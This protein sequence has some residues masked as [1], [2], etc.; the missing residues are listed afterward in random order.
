MS[1]ENILKKQFKFSDIDFQETSERYYSNT[2]VAPDLILSVV[3]GKGNYSIPTEK[4]SN[5]QEYDAY[6]FG[7]WDKDNIYDWLTADLLGGQKG[8]NDVIG[9]ATK[10]EIEEL[11][12]KALVA[13]E[14]ATGAYDKH[15]GMKDTDEFDEDFSSKYAMERLQ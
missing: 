14:A 3:A 2:E 11:V 5:P 1:W 9:Y 12:A 6:E 8:S 10:A 7:F 15:V 4:L 13:Y